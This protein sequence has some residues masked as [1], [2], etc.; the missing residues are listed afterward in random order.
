M[1]LSASI[2]SALLVALVR[3]DRST[4]QRGTI[5]ARQSQAVCK[6]MQ[7]RAGARRRARAVIMPQIP[8]GLHRD[9]LMV[10]RLLAPAHQ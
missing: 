4:G 2:T 9:K 3:A 8:A 6:G 5:K 1:W 10:D 7:G